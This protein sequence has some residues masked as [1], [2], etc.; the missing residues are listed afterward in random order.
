MSFGTG[1]YVISITFLAFW[2]NNEIT[3]KEDQPERSTWKEVFYN[4]IPTKC[5]FPEKDPHTTTNLPHSTDCTKF[6]KCFLGKGVLQECPLMIEGDSCTRLHYNR[7]EQ[8]CDWPWRAGC[9]SCPGKDE[10]WPEHK[11]AHE[12]DK[13]KLYYVCINGV[14][15]LEHCPANTC[16]SRTCQS[17]VVDRTGGNCDQNPPNPPCGCVNGDKKCHE[18]NC[19]M[20]YE[21]N[22]N[23]WYANTCNG[24]LHFDRRTKT[25]TT[26]DI[27][28]CPYN[29]Q[30]VNLLCSIFSTLG[31]QYF[32]SKNQ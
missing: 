16:F 9:I 1:I 24:G 11:I 27:A 15:R 4:C 23:S 8:V 5:P 20:Y 25:C 29:G 26:P 6:Y 3:A 30:N 22:N 17:C 18:C 10:N 32:H 28:K 14:K 13:C 7:R 2:T 21:C 12:T 19:N 31:M